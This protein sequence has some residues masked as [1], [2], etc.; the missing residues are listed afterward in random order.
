MFLGS[1]LHT[2]L[3]SDWK[4]EPSIYLQILVYVQSAIIFVGS[5]YDSELSTT[6]YFQRHHPCFYFIFRHLFCIVSVYTFVFVFLFL[7]I[8]QDGT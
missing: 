3:L 6:S 1:A 2:F 7:Q 8:L 5:L 4:K